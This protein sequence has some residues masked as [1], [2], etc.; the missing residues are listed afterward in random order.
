M[1][2]LLSGRLGRSFML[3]VIGVALFFISIIAIF[4]NEGN[5]VKNIRALSEMNKKAVHIDPENVKSS[6]DGA[7]VHLFGILKTDEVITDEVTGISKTAIRLRR[8]VEMY[9]WKEIEIE[10]TR[11]DGNTKETTT[12]YEYEKVWSR[13][14]I[15]SNEF[16]NQELHENPPMILESTEFYVSSATIGKLVAGRELLDKVGNY[17]KHIVDSIPESFTLF[18][19]KNKTLSDGAIFIGDDPSAPNIGDYRIGYEYVQPVHTL[20][21]IAELNNG[22]LGHYVAHNGKKKLL[23]EES[24]VSKDVMIS[25]AMQSNSTMSWA[26]RILSFLAMFA[27]FNF[28]ARPLTAVTDLFPFIGT[29]AKAG[30]TLVSFLS[31]III[32][33]VIASVAWIAFRP[34]VSLILM[35][36]SAGA[37]YAFYSLHKKNVKS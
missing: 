7:L 35:A 29:V 32:T 25:N 5:S 11:G 12:R 9:Q 33:S 15:L 4:I 28:I 20:S 23:V 30:V 18:S 2:G 10:E 27:S 3:L 37:V 13:V 31:A 34:F 24:T 26:F 36:I 22:V 6:S 21:I 14:E 19:A 16:K 8:N 17:E 1:L